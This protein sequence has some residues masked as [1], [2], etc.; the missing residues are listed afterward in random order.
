MAPELLL[1]FAAGFLAAG[2]LA[3]G[4][5]ERV[6]DDVLRE[7]PFALAVDFD[8]GLGLDPEPLDVA[9]PAPCPLREAD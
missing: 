9:R 1:R 8:L 7:L 6:P 2:F 4:L 3:A 5:L